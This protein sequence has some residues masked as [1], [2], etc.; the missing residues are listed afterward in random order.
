MFCFT[1]VHVL[2]GNYDSKTSD[3]YKT[4]ITSCYWAGTMEHGGEPLPSS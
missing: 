2:R 3:V 1:V 4:G